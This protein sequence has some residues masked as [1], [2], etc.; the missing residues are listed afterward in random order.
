MVGFASQVGML[1]TVPLFTHYF[2]TTHGFSVYLCLLHLKQASFTW[3]HGAALALGRR[4]RQA[5]PQWDGA[6]PTPTHTT[7][8]HLTLFP[9]RGASRLHAPE[10]SFS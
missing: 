4:D 7:P 3:C 5:S 2:P 1:N 10:H 9:G 6:H 8:L